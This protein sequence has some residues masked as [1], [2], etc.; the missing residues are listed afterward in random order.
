VLVDRPAPR[1][2]RATRSG[3]GAYAGLDELR[4]AARR[5]TPVPRRP[6]SRAER[7]PRIQSLKVG[8]NKVFGY[9]I[10]VTRANKDSVARPITSAARR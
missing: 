2:A 3:P 5:R 7:T 6:A 9:F 8:Y 4:V 1:S 10:E